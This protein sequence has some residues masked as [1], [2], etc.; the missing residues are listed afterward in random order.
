[1][2]INYV[3]PE[4]CVLQELIECAV[5]ASSATGSNEGFIED[6]PINWD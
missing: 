6:D 4:V 5:M 2:E 1:M 3:S